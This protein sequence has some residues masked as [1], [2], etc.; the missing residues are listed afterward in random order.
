VLFR[1]EDAAWKSFRNLGKRIQIMLPE[2]LNTYDVLVNDIIVF[3]RASLDAVTARLGGAPATEDVAVAE[4]E[5][6]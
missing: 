5:A 3:S 6:Q 2:E 1:T 4:E